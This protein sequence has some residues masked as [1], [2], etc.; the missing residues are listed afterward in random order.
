MRDQDLM[1]EIYDTAEALADAVHTAN[2]CAEAM[3]QLI[4]QMADQ[5]PDRGA[6]LLSVLTAA[7]HYLAVARSQADRVARLTMTTH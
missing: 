2:G 5:F 6:C 3:M 7:D 4:D 1:Q